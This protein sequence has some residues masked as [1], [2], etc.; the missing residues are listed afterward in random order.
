MPKLAKNYYYGKNGERKVNCYLVNIPKTILSKTNISDG[1]EIKISVKNNKIIIEKAQSTKS[2]AKIALP[3]TKNNFV[4]YNVISKSTGERLKMESA[5]ITAL[6]SGLC[7]AVPSIIA[8]ITTNKKNNDVVIYRINELDKKVHE[9]NNL[10]DR[11]Y[12]VETRVT[13]LE[14]NAKDGK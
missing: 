11:M 1:D 3:L 12:K 8:T 13:V 10:I 2:S 14:D 7:V 4:W 6:I 5:I 9:H